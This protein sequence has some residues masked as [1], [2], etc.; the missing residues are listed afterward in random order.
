MQARPRQL[1]H[2]RGLALDDAPVLSLLDATSVPI[3]V[4]GVASKAL[5][6]DHDRVR[7]APRAFGALPDTVPLRLDHTDTIVGTVEQLSYD[8]MARSWSLPG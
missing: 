6:L 8:A 2:D 3:I 1:R 4:S 7:I 5:T